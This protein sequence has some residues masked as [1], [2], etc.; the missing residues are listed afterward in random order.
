MSE[1]RLTPDKRAKLLSDMGFSA[2]PNR[3]IWVAVAFARVEI[4]ELELLNLN[5]AQVYGVAAGKLMKAA[6]QL[7]QI[8]QGSAEKVQAGKPITAQ[9]L[10]IEVL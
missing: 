7:S 3:S 2:H 9:L 10:S 8:V 4:N 5:E 6:N 1:E